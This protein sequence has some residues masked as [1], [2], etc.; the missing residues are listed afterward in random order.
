MCFY[1]SQ[2]F[3]TCC[4]RRIY[5]T[6]DDDTPYKIDCIRGSSCTAVEITV[7]SYTKCLIC[8]DCECE[9]ESGRLPVLIFCPNSNTVLMFFESI[10]SDDDFL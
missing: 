5:R 7:E 9:C 6:P 2:A 1:Q 10:E 4:K 8:I 3:C